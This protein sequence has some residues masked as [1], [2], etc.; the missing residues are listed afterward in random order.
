MAVPTHQQHSLY[1]LNLFFECLLES[2]GICKDIAVWQNTKFKTEFFI[3]EKVLIKKK[4]KL[5]LPD[6][7]KIKIP[8]VLI[9]YYHNKAI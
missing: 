1:K 8:L 4:K 6:L 7:R 9:S 5:R 3:N 2:F